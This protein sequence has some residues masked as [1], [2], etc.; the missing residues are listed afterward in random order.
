MIK[1]SHT[2]FPNGHHVKYNLVKNE[3]DALFG[4][5]R[6]GQFIY[7]WYNICKENINESPNQQDKLK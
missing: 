7:A 4:Y 6:Q 5:N 3:M 2:Y 1:I